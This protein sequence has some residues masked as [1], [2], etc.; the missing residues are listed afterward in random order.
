MLTLA[1]NTAQ[2]IKIELESVPEKYHK[3][4]NSPH[5]ALGVI[6]E[7]YLELEQEI[8]FGE[9][10]AKA[11]LDYID[12]DSSESQANIK[13]LYHK[14]IKLEAVQVAAMCARLIQEL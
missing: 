1:P 4:F 12:P 2:L 7:E 10:Q 5:E 14:R 8:F 11:E 9:K 3:A 13:K 6:R